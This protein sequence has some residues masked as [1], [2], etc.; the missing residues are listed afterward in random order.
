V[1]VLAWDTATPDTVVAF[2]GAELRHVPAAGERPGHGREL[3]ALVHRV[4]E[5]AGARWE[6]V[7]R[8]A[9][10][11]GPG[12]FTGLRIGL[13]TARAL[14][15]ARVLPLVGVSSLRALAAGARAEAE[16]ESESEIVLAAIDARR[17]EVFAAAWHGT[18]DPV[19]EPAALVPEALAATLAGLPGPVLAIG[20]GA[21]RYRA[22][23]EAAGAVVP[24]DASSLHRVSAREIARIGDGARPGALLDVL[25]EYIRSPDAVPLSAR[26]E[27]A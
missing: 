23:F 27:P 15:Q 6:D 3:L 16:S 24:A 18:D 4:L 12:S 1:S 20:D 25:P 14:A 13:A 22:V 26:R 10:G 8:I 5:D 11:T 19:L 21:L 17:G 2:G 9:V 7:E